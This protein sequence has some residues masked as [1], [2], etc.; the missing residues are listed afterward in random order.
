[1]TDQPRFVRVFLS[2]PGDVADE[3]GIAR[4]VIE[5]AAGQAPFRS[6]LAVRIVAWDNLSSRTP[7]LATLT[8]QEAINR[9]LPKPSECD[10]VVV[11]FWSR[12]GTQLPHPEY[13]KPNGD[14]YYSGTE[15]EYLDAVRASKETGKPLVVVYR[16]T[17]EPSFKPSDSAF[18]HK[19]EQWQRVEEFFKQFNRS[20][21]EA[22]GGYNPYETPDEFRQLFEADIRE[23]LD[24]SL[25]MPTDE[26]P[27]QEE[28]VKLVTQEIWQD[29]PFPGLRAFT[30]DDAPI[31]FGRGHETDELIKK[32]SENRFVAVVG[33]SGSGKSSLVAAG[34]LP[35]LK[36]RAIEGSQ[37]WLLPYMRGDERREWT[38]L[39]FTP[40]EVSDNP[41]LSLA[42]RLAPMVGHNAREVAEELSSEPNLL[43]QLCQTALVGKP[44][45]AE[46]MLFVDQFE[47]LFTLVTDDALRGSFIDML[48]DV[49]QTERVR[50]VVTLRSDFYH[51]CVEYPMLAQL[52]KLSTYPLSV[53]EVDALLEMITRPARRA[54]LE[55]DAGLPGQ[56]IRDTGQE[57]GAL[58][59]M[60]Y[61]LDELYETCHENGHKV[62]SLHRYIEL[63]GVQGAIGTR[64]ENTFV[65]LNEDV[66]AALPRVFRRLVEVDERGILTRQR[67]SLA[68]FEDD[69]A[70]RQLIETFTK[71][72]L[73]TASDIAK[74][75]TIEVAHEALFRIWPRLGDWIETAQDDLRLLRQ[76]RLAAQE[77]DDQDRK[78]A[79]LWP[80][81]RLQPVYQM[82]EHLQPELNSVTQE[83]IK[84][85]AEHLLED[86]I[87]WHGETLNQH[88]SHLAALGE[89]LAY[90][91]DPRSG[92]GLGRDRLPDI[93]WCEV[94]GGQIIGQDLA[95]QS[96]YIAKYLITYVQFEAFLNDPDGFNNDARWT[97]FPDYFKQEMTEQH[98]K[99]ANHPRDRVSW[100]QAMAFCR[101]ID[102][103]L[104]QHARPHGE[105]RLP[106]SQEW[107]QAASGNDPSNV[108][109]WGTEWD[110]HRANTREAGLGHTTAVGLYLH[111]ASPFGA[112]DMSGNVW[113]WDLAGGLRGGAYSRYRN[114]A[115]CAFG[116][117]AIKSSKYVDVGFRV[118]CASPIS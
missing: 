48:V 31:F 65:E 13:Q 77:W 94:P 51:R 17:E 52:F 103:V 36:N 73:L 40:G 39:R 18:M 68:Q 84:S 113:E 81:V 104:P 101:W 10:I 106:T 93:E 20:G 2:S 64:A 32:V 116:Y 56:I 60:A 72:R 105:I 41:F 110:S 34:L 96:F 27:V 78:A 111:G 22:V 117:D 54:D 42:V 23:L 112:L 49:A 7:M 4:K 75:P 76:V 50:T 53:P 58:A 66:Q 43:S 102:A 86:I 71:A 79:F 83:F 3:R 100:Y 6:Q 11:L 108:F 12:M 21:G 82:I 114:R 1:M 26:T 16:R 38:G 30:P 95:V 97:G 115:R 63:G 35:R 89:R 90:T 24:T 67:A 88:H 44:N 91:G 28:L 74:E 33:A 46:V 15:W 25:K 9:R 45:W 70:G 37:D 29:S 92:V 61:T 55:F 80:D 85:E 47:E 99:L 87:E 107:R 5:D 118:V 98:N 59:L 62:L 14:P 8:P 57:P 19:Y 109:P 69:T